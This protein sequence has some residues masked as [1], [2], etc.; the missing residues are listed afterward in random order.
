[1]TFRSLTCVFC[2]ATG[3]TGFVFKQFRGED[4]LSAICPECIGR[5]APWKPLPTAKEE[6]PEPDPKQL[7]LPL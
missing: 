2:G 3:T 6:Q 7:E 1:M 5:Y 4:H